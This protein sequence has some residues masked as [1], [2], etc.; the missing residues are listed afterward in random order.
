MS[1]KMTKE[2]FKRSFKSGFSYPW[3]KPSR[4]WNILWVLLPIF[5]WF[6]LG[7]YS[8]KIVKSL[9][10]GNTEQLPAFGSF[11][12]NFKEG[13]FILVFMIPTIVALMVMNMVPLI[14]ELVTVLS[15]I[16]LLPWLMINF[17]MK[18]TFESLWDINRAYKVVTVHV[19]E[20]LFALLKSIVFGAVYF[21]LCFVLVGI[22]CLAFGKNFFLA[23][24]YRRHR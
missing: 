1:E 20:Y 9:V 12:Q 13:I 14:G 2:E 21:V 10:S 8:K 23:D 4:L 22:P 19:V 6:A 7:G 15:V 3:G 24:F 17:F 11:W 18:E 16:F 5:G